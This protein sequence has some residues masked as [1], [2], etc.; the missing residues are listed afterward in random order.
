MKKVLLGMSG[1]VDS[2]VAAHLL[3]QQGYEVH[4]AFMQLWKDTENPDRDKRDIEKVQ[5]AAQY[6]NIPLQILDLKDIFFEE[7]VQEFVRQYQR[8]YTPNPCVICNQKFKYDLMEKASVGNFDFFATGHYARIFNIDDEYQ[9]WQA[10]HLN[11]DQSYVLYHLSQKKLS[12]ILLPLGE[13]DKTEI[14]EIAEKIGFDNTSL[15]DSQDICFISRDKSYR[16]LLLRFNAMGE[17]GDFVDPEGNILGQHLGIG[18]YT[19]GQRKHLGMAFGKKVFVSKIDP[20]KNQVTVSTGEQIFENKYLVA[21]TYFNSKELPNLPIQVEVAN[22][23]QAKRV[24]AIIQPTVKE[25]KSINKAKIENSK[26]ILATD[27]EKMVEVH[28]LEPQRAITPGQAA[29]F[30]QKERCLGGGIIA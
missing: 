1:G 5:K 4:G 6:L 25:S 11:K 26:V 3:Q 16:D 13:Y 8:G 18:H 24:P 23:Y 19:I 9:L 7:V 27:S 30:Y 29:V 15:S 20:I 28:C 10:A 21:N 12:R 17:P 2:T 14:R 22:R